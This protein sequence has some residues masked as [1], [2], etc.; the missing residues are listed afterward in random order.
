MVDGA[1]VDG[2]GR[3]I[4]PEV[5]STAVAGIVVGK[6]WDGNV[7]G[8]GWAG[9]IVGTVGVL[10]APKDAFRAL[11]DKFFKDFMAS[12]ATLF[13]ALVASTTDVNIG[14]AEVFVSEV[15]VAVI[16]VGM[17]GTAGLPGTDGMD[18]TTG[19]AFINETGLKGFVASALG[20]YTD[21]ATGVTG[22]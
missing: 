8:A 14:V 11:L 18:I 20:V 15:S 1:C 5:T 4:V 17:A 22:E 3:I 6:G 16:L 13:S 9:Y 2:V 19:F 10:K 7:A 12:A 21:G